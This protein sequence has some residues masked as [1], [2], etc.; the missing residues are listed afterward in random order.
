MPPAQA[1]PPVARCWCPPAQPLPGVQPSAPPPPMCRSV[2]RAVSPSTEK[3]PALRPLLPLPTWSLMPAPPIPTELP[4][5][6]APPLAPCRPVPMPT[7]RSAPL[8]TAG[9]AVP[10]GTS[11]DG[12]DDAGATA[13]ASGAAG[14]AGAEPPAS[15][16][17]ASWR[18]ARRWTPRALRPPAARRQRLASAVLSL[19][20]PEP[21][22]CSGV[23]LAASARTYV[24]R[25]R[26][27]AAQIAC[28]TPVPRR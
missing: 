27:S 5:P 12:T 9:A 3:M 22:V 21:T 13:V 26:S 7:T 6:P 28:G 1:S 17:V 18:R 24:R 20:S 16:A 8:C 11:A 25:R 23:A 10:A 2:A 19:S 4:I 14:V 15:P